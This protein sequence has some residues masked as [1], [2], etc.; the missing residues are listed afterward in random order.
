MSTSDAT[1]SAVCTASCQDFGLANFLA[2][3]CMLIMH[4]HQVGIGISTAN[5]QHSFAWVLMLIFR[6]WTVDSNIFSSRERSESC[7][8]HFDFLS[9][10]LFGPVSVA[11]Y[12]WLLTHRKRAI[13]T[14]SWR[15]ITKPCTV[16]ILLWTSFP[17]QRLSASYY[18]SKQGR[19]CYHLACTFQPYYIETD[20]LK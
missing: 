20:L 9:T 16:G 11:A 13:H 19:M 5:D 10:H 4:T 3:L 2:C 1:L 8:M 18:G 14:W 6:C 7:Q 17:L 15:F 12:V